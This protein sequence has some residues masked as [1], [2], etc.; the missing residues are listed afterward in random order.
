MSI[1]IEREAFLAAYGG[2]Y[3]HSPWIAERAFEQG[4]FDAC[5]TLLSSLRSV[6]EHASEERQLELLRAHPD[7]AG[8]LA[9]AGRLT[10]DSTAEQRAAGLDFLTE[11]EASRFTELN[12]TYTE[13]FG[14]PFILCA[15]EHD[16]SSILEVFERRLNN[17]AAAERATALEQ[18]HRI[19]KYRLRKSLELPAHPMGKLSTHIL[20]TM[21]GGPAPGVRIDLRRDDEIVL[22]TTT[23]DDGRTDAPL[24]S[25]ASI[26]AGTWELHFHI[27]DYFRSRGVASPFLDIVPIRFQIANPD[28]GYHVPLLASPWSYSTYRGS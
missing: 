27:G 21:H 10:P 20:D 22:S 4:P 24:L 15:A 23:N 5:D 28:E 1:P 3:E 11:A 13:R 19:A 25:P 18:V 6:V 7:L 12:T 16:K 9:V 17:A 26:K 14:H 8:K 2:L